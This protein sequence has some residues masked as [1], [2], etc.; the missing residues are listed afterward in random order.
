MATVVAT[1]C[2]HPHGFAAALDV[3]RGAGWLADVDDLRAALGL[4]AHLEPPVRV[5]LVDGADSG[6]LGWGDVDD[7]L[8]EASFGRLMESALVS[9]VVRAG[10]EVSPSP[11]EAMSGSPTY[12]KPVRLAAARRSGDVA[13]ALSTSTRDERWMNPL[14]VLYVSVVGLWLVPGHQHDVAARA[15]AVAV[16]VRDGTVVAT[17]AGHGRISRVRPLALLDEGRD[18]ADA[19]RAAIHALLPSLAEELRQTLRPAGVRS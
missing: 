9:E 12:L 17:A 8:I 15:D 19:E 18:R 16:A 2:A 4:P 3:P 14:G 6:R 1:G 11:R 5:V 7:R 13:V 10:H